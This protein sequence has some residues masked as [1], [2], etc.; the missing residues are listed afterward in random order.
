MPRRAALPALADQNAAKGGIVTLDRAMSLLSAFTAAQ[1]TLTLAALAEHT[2]LYKSTVLRMLASLEHAYL[3]QRLPDG[4]YTLGA[5]VE[6][7]H[8]IFAATFSLESVVLP[9]LKALVAETR[10]SAAFYVPRGDWR[11]CLYR[12]DSPRPVRDHLKPGDLLPMGSGAGGRILQ[13]YA[14]AQDPLSMKIRR[15]QVVV[16]VGDRIPELAGLGAPVFDSAN[17]LAGALTL[18]M[19]AERL[20]PGYAEP[21]RQAARKMTLLL[22]GT[23]PPPLLA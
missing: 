9:V 13:A 22:G 10:E 20:D 2:R 12:V 17:A 7:L 3:V 19:P 5:E 1:P 18:T 14:G 15:E 11:L 21:V 23:Y 6:R 8:R 16:L 4:R